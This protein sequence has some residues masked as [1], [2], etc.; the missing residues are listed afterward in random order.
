MPRS[1][2]R[3]TVS[4][5]DSGPGE[6]RWLCDWSWSQA[7]AAVAHGD[8]EWG[9]IDFIAGDFV[10]VPEDQ[11]APN[12]AVAYAVRPLGDAPTPTWLLRSIVGATPLVLVAREVVEAV[13]HDEMPGAVS[14]HVSRGAT[15]APAH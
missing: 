14:W 3:K 4:V 7:R 5:Y 1:G 13:L 15:P 6:L 9:Q 10:V 11:V 8:A 2:K 12:P